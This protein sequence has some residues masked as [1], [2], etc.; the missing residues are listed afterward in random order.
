MLLDLGSLIQPSPGLEDLSAPFIKEEIDV[1]V[2]SL[3]IDKAPGPN[4][5]NGQFLKSCWPIIK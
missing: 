1:V 2:S 3:P 5:F 4:R